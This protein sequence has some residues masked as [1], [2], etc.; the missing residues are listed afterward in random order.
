V[1]LKDYH[2]SGKDS[3][4]SLPGKYI[5]PGLWDMHTHVWYADYFFPLFLANGV[6]GFRDMFGTVGQLQAWRL[7]VQGGDKRIPDLF[8]SGPIVDGPKP[9]WPGSVAVSNAEDGRRTVD[10]IKLKLKT[11]F[12]K[13]YS[14]LSRES[15]FSIAEE[16]KKMK[17]DF[18]GHVPNVVT[19]LEAAKAGQK[20][21]EHLF[22]I[23]EMVSDSSDVYFKIVQGLAVGIPGK[24]LG[25]DTILL[26]RLERRKMLLKTFNNQK[27]NDLAKEFSSTN[28][29]ICPTLVVNYNIGHLDDSSLAADSR[30]KYVTSF[31]QSFWNPKQDRF[32]AQPTE[33]FEINRMEFEK[34]LMMIPVLHHAG[35][36]LLA[37]TDTPNP[38][39]FPGFSFHDELAW[40]VKAGLT[41][42]EALQTATINP[43]I[44]F[45][46]EKDFGTVEKN[47]IA[48]L[49]ILDKNPLL[50]IRNTTSINTVILRGSMMDRH[51]LDKMLQKVLAIA[52]Q[53]GL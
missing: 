48:S 45:S 16:C 44:Y 49:V 17:I 35:V 20:S 33:Y 40:M 2:K 7:S 4:I 15:Y 52:S 47:K 30:M 50:D 14:L 11:D 34:K 6:T 51:Q 24:N 39:C 18:A 9:V 8:F 46:I 23:L 29:W 38:Y 25:V 43:A 19:A 3:I 26:D 53:H 28:T 37:G 32:R 21:Q 1:P 36:R 10:S 13:V 41:P 12:V 42:A 27:L 31:L 5:I 22:G